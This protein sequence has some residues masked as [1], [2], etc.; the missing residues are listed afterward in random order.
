MEMQDV[1]NKLKRGNQL[2]FSRD[3]PC[4]QELILLIS[5]QKHRTLV[6]WALDGARGPVKRLKARYP[7]ENRPETAV[8]LCWDWARGRVKMP[9]AKKALLRVHA[10]AKELTAP[11]DIAL[12]HAVGQACAAI[13][14]ETHAVGL[15][16]YE[17]TAIVRE[18]GI[19]NCRQAVEEAIAAYT[20]SLEALAE[21]IDSPPQEWAAFLLDDSRPNK[22]RLLLEKRT[23][24]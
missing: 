21:T 3:S 2:L 11:V 13:H 12:C 9:E 14:V 16:F 22:E 24:G 10:M 20:G 7:G 17:L 23:K 6:K 15:P 19:E 18:R 1:R 8:A 4:L 5:R